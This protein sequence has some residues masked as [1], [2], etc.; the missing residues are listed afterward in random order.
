[1]YVLIICMYMMEMLNLVICWEYG[2]EVLIH[3]QLHLIVE[4]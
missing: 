2:A 3:G 4:Q 1:M